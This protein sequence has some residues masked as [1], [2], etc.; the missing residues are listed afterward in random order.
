MVQRRVSTPGKLLILRNS[1][2]TAQLAWLITAASSSA[3]NAGITSAVLIS[4]D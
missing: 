4:T 3:R 2:Q 1:A